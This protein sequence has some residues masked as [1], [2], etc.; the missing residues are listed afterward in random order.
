MRCSVEPRRAIN[1]ERGIVNGVFLT[2]F[3]E[4]QLS[5]RLRFRRRE[6]Y[7]K[8]LLG[9]WIDGVRKSVDLT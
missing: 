3:A 6:P 8:V 1:E 2:E 9:L 4:K 7:V 5:E